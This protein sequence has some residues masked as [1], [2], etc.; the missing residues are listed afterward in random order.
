MIN[1]ENIAKIFLI[2]V[3]VAIALYIIYVMVT[4]IFRLPDVLEEH[5]PTTNQVQ[6][7]EDY[8]S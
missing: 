3:A 1:F 4:A 6:T 5:T 7:V 8:L 2:I